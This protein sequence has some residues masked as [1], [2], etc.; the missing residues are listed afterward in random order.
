MLSLSRVRVSV[1]RHGSQRNFLVHLSHR[2]V[3]CL[4][5]RAGAHRACR[6]TVS[7]Q[8]VKFLRRVGAD[9]RKVLPVGPSLCQPKLWQ[10][11]VNGAID[12]LLTCTASGSKQNCERS[13][14]TNPGRCEETQGGNYAS[15]IE[16]NNPLPT[17]TDLTTPCARH[18]VNPQTSALPITRHQARQTAPRRQPPTREVTPTAVTPRTTQAPCLESCHRAATRLPHL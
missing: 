15:G 17:T 9:S 18:A 11:T 2:S 16:P 3:D 12:P 6:Y 7:V 1:C 13:Q 10:Y 8:Y 14:R 4:I 5:E